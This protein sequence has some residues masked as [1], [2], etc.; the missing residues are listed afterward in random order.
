MDNSDSFGRG[1]AKDRQLGLHLSE[2]VFTSHT[3]PCKTMAMK[4]LGQ[5]VRYL[6]TQRGLSLKKAAK[7]LK[8]SFSAFAKKERGA[9]S[10][11]T[12]DEQIVLAKAFGLD[13]SALN[14]LWTNGWPSRRIVPSGAGIPIIGRAF[15]GDD[16][17]DDDAFIEP[18]P[19]VD[20]GDITDDNAKAV[21]VVGDCMVP[22]VCQDDTLIVVSVP[23]PWTTI[24]QG[25][26]VYVTFTKKSGRRKENGIG[27]FFR[28]E[29]GRIILNRDNRAFPPMICT[30]DEIG[31]VYVAIE[32]RTK[33]FGVK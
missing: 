1:K 6:R 5:A 10:R 26:V 30:D 13:V 15:A 3:G 27:R 28:Q 31:Q 22:T 7:L 19:M 16:H 11:F 20:W 21:I 24:I 4:T 9:G 14:K 18:G 2:I 8:I 17:D 33:S 23:K 25:A 32:R 12:P 29:D